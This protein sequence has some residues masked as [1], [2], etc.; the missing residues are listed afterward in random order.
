[1]AGGDGNS[2]F[3]SFGDE[4]REGLTS[5]VLKFIGVYGKELPV[6]FGNLRL[7]HD[8]KFKLCKKETAENGRILLAEFPFGEICNNKR[9]SGN[10]VCK[11]E[12][13]FTLTD[14]FP[15]LRIKEET[16]DAC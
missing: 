1:M 4:R 11:S 15:D 2:V 3:T 13:A 7:G 14:D 12:C 9:T 10:S 5:E 16:G 6:L 8:V